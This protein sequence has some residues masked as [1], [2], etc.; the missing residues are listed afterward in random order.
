MFKKKLIFWDL[1]YWQFLDVCHTLDGMHINKNMTESLLDTLM[2]AKGV[3]TR[4]VNSPKMSVIHL[5]SS[6]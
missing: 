5:N 6:I 4:H 3:G 2:E 1:S